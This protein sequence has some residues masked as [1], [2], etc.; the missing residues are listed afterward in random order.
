MEGTE[1][2][3]IW[4][5]GNTGLRNPMRI[6][7]GFRAFAESP[8]VGDLHGKEEK[9]IPFEKYLNEKGIIHTGEGTKTDGTYARKWR[10]MF[11][12]YGFIYDKYTGKDKYLQSALGKA[13]DITPF[14]EMFLKADT[15][16]AM[17][18][19]FL[20]SLG[21]EQYPLPET[22]D[23]LFSPFRWILALMLK[24][25]ERTGSSE[26]SRIEFAL[27]GQAT[28]PRYDIDEV[29]DEILDLRERR[30]K[31]PAKKKFDREERLKRAEHY[32]HDAKN[33]NDYCDMNL[34]YLRIS[35]V[36]QRKGRGIIIVP[37]KHVIAEQMARASASDKPRLDEL[38]MLT[39]GAPLPTDDITVAKQV[40]KELEVILN[41]RHILFDISDLPLA[42]AME[43]NIA[44][45]RLEELLSQT[46]E[47]NYA[48]EQKDQ[49]REIADY[50]TLLIE[51]GGK[52]EYDE[53]NV[54]EVPKDEM[55]AYLEWTLW[56]A[57]LA[58]DNMVSKPYE[59]RGF[60]LDSDFLPVSAAG[61]GRGDLYCEFNDYM[62]LT[63]VTMS[64]S[65]RQEAMEGEP[66]R[67]HVADAV[68]TCKKPVYGLFVAVKID[69]NT[70]ETFRHGVWYSS[71]VRRRLN[72]LPLSL[73][74]FREYFVK[75][76]ATNKVSAEHFVELIDTCTQRRDE[77]ETPAWTNYIDSTVKYGT[78]QGAL[79]VAEPRAAYGVDES[80]KFPYGI[81]FGTM[82]KNNEKNI[83]GC[84]VGVSHDAIILAYNQKLKLANERVTA[85]EFH[86]GL[87]SVI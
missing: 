28:D 64:T 56:R 47:I 34:R 32:S 68:A 83:P 57:A 72:I 30:K 86:K 70:A 74:Q 31:A 37:A 12:R 65:S 16:P 41:E 78:H 66:V 27:W 77:M 51:G 82:V 59:V 22:T 40:L 21:V 10:L 36:V 46:D 25:E 1:N 20:R 17:Q 43:V 24:L 4:L 38:K 45:S 69:T 13:D 81:S 6:Q 26:I 29:V 50:M 79:S 75:M 80:K 5:I 73:N 2:I 67:R 87:F 61:G 42:T 18:E 23:K 63:E 53:D 54:I 49:W 76:F 44:R 48:K 14:G 35:G 58:I 9:E 19:C 84:V 52:K 71:G 85:D 60:R 62:I 7:D 3:S 39:E 11:A 55:P 15:I 33:F 8:F